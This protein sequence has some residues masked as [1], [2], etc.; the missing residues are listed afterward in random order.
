MLAIAPGC[1]RAEEGDE[2]AGGTAPIP[3]G[4]FGALTGSEAGL[5]QYTDMGAT[6]A[7]E[8]INAGGG[9]LGRGLRLVREDNRS[10]AGESATVVRKLL[11]R[12]R[13]VA[14]VGDGNSGRCLEAGPL[15][16]AAGVPMV[17]PAATN[18]RVT[19]IGDHVFR[20][21]F[22]DP[23]QG[24]VM[25]RFARRTLRLG[26]VGLL[27][28]MSAPYS[29]GLAEVFRAE[30]VAEG[31]EIGGEAR[32]TGGD[33]DFRAQLTALR[34]AGCG[35][36]FAPCYYPAGGL[37]LRQARE[38]GMD[39]PMLGSDGWEAP[40]LVEVAGAAADGAYFPVHFSAENADAAAAG[41][42]RR[43]ERRHGRRPT[44]VSA[45]A[46]DTL[47]LIADALRRAGST[48]GDRI[49]DALA[50]TRGFAGVTGTISIDAERNARKPAVIVGVRGGSFRFLGTVAP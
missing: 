17:S 2:G 27:V 16:Q 40:E 22:T 45:L 33:R 19:A 12:D 7:L 9:V 29:T 31:G 11:S 50:A 39:V 49:R 3:I 37:I 38:L 24:T 48:R 35:A 44:G 46:Y 23:F 15:C 30:F 28:D 42:V 41:F 13:V 1:R 20:V 4:L 36:V 8:E 6:L 18:P 43:F 21:C 5:G 26:R 14:V 10:R 47:A 34:S 32:F 25:A